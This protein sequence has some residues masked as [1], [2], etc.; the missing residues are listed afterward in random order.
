MSDVI[1]LDTNIASLLLKKNDTRYAQYQ[2][3][4]QG[5]ILAISLMTVAELYQW[6]AIRQWGESRIQDMESVLSSQCVVLPMDT[7]TCRYWGSIRA[8]C[9]RQGRPVS[10][11]DAWIAASGLQYGLPLLTHNVSDF[12]AVSGL[13]LVVP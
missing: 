8:Q 11:Q 12:E 6:A 13:Q 10:A 4:L 9:R 2:E 5:K 3:C 1:L 7:E